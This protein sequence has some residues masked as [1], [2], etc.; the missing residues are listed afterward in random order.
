MPRSAERRV[1]NSGSARSGS[2]SARAKSAYGSGAAARARTGGRAR[3]YK[4]RQAHARRPGGLGMLAML[5]VLVAAGA[6]GWQLITSAPA[7]ASSSSAAAGTT[8]GQG[9]NGHSGLA[10]VVVAGGPGGSGS[11]GTGA[12]LRVTGISPANGSSG[13]V[14]ARPITVRFSSPLAKGSPAPSLSPREAGNW[15]R[16][17][18]TFYFKASSAYPPLSK[19][20]LTIPGGPNGVKAAGGSYLGDSRTISFTVAQ[21]SLMRLQQMLAMLHYLPLRFSPASGSN[22]RAPGSTGTGRSAFTSPRGTFT[23]RYPN[24]PSQLSSLWKPGAANVVT[25]GAVMAFERSAGL[26][27][28]AVPGPAVWSQLLQAVAT[29]QLNTKGYSYVLV[30]KALPET[31]T[32]WHDGRVVLTSPTN[33]GIPQT[34]TQKGTYP[35]YLRYQF[36]IMRGTNPNG[37]KYADPVHWINYFHGSQAVHGFVR[38]SYGFPQSLGCV[39]LPVPTAKAAWP[40]IHYGTLVTVY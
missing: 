10:P 23:W 17:G 20:T 39:E 36:Q 38:A 1:Y 21:G 6:V 26:P 35:V 5:A 18:S 15:V 24:T 13:V 11:G 29:H 28:S 40:W 16:S 37:S 8:S 30:N 33:T 4:A 22:Q 27:I 14:P 34:P 32:L 25:T 3:T 7:S 31:L 2:A 9:T 19:V 12:S